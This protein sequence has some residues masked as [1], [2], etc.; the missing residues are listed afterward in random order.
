VPGVPIKD[1]DV[2]RQELLN[3][4]G[5]Y[6]Y[7]KEK[8]ELMQHKSQD[9]FVLK[10]GLLY[11][12]E[13]KSK[14]IVVPLSLRNKVLKMCHES[15]LA[16][17]KGVDATVDFIKR[18]YWWP[19]LLSSV[20]DFI[21]GCE[22]CLKFK[23]KLT[24]SGFLQTI[25]TSSPFQIMACD[26]LEIGRSNRGNCNCFVLVDLFSGFIWAV[27]TRRLR[28]VDAMEALKQILQYIP[29]FPTLICDQG[30]HF[31]S[32]EFKEFVTQVGISKL[33]IVAANAHFSNG[34]AEAGIKKIVQ[35][36]K[37]Y[38]QKDV[39]SWMSYFL[40]HCKQ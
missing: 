13:G 33:N 24:K 8:K 17:H 3:S 36:W 30:P 25:R 38:L 16:G 1:M 10:D 11:R 31:I 19:K 6:D 39:S 21:Q 22:K 14:L 5:V 32:Q 7:I 15:L 27:P 34:S 37:F 4:Q 23:S 20:T 18:T 35:T 2:W 28:S 9:D 26:F 29:N 12:M 40:W